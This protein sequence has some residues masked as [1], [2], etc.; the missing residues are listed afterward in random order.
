MQFQLFLKFFV[1]FLATFYVLPNLIRISNHYGIYDLPDERKQHQIPVPFLGGIAIFIS[2]HFTQHI[3]FMLNIPAPGYKEL[4]GFFIASNFLIGLADDFF[5]Y[6]PSRKFLVQF[7]ISSVL[8]YVSDFLLPFDQLIPLLQY[9]PFSNYILTFFVVVAII[10]AINLID[11]LDGLAATLVLISSGIY[12]IIFYAE[13]NLYFLSM[14]ISLA[15]A[16]IGFLIYNRPNAMI[17]MGDSGS[18]LIGSITAILTLVFIANGNPETISINNRFQIGF[19]LVAI[20]AMDLVRLFIWRLIQKRSPFVGDNRHLHHLL[21]IRGFT[22]KQTLATIIL[23]HLIIILAS[24]FF[25]GAG[26]F[27]PFLL[28]TCAV[29]TCIIWYLKSSRVSD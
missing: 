8:I 2:F 4:L 28:T 12:V 6:R 3:N 19:A 25:Q 21:Q 16:L 24:V 22:V 15:G 23:L 7:I 18:F 1:S 9:I 26:T 5:D 10:N 11:G 27:F 14:A 17:Y 13:N 20:P 29:Y